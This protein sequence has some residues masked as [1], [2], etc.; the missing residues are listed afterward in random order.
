ML[1]VEVL[2]EI[3]EMVGLLELVLRRGS[4]DFEI[5]VGL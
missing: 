5:F 3:F 4:V 2:S 1:R